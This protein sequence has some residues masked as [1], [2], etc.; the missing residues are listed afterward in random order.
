MDI[1]LPGT[2]GHLFP[3]GRRKYSL[4]MPTLNFVHTFLRCRNSTL[5]LL[6]WPI[7][8]LV[9]CHIGFFIFPSRPNS[10]FISQRNAKSSECA[11]HSPTRQCSINFVPSWSFRASSFSSLYK[12]RIHWYDHATALNPPLTESS[13]SV[14]FKK[15]GSNV[16]SFS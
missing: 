3:D 7:H 14:Y 10:P 2:G 8:L 1:F 4:V 15:S 16:A 12:P 6:F 13:I 9:N 5:A 11:Y